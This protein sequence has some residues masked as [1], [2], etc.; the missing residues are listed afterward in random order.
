MT[1]SIQQIAERIR[2]LTERVEKAGATY[3]P[4]EGVRSAA[5]R[6]LAL[7]EKW[8]RGGLS[9]GEASDQGIGS[10]VQRAVNLKNGDAISL[11]TVKRMAAFFSRHAKNYAPEKKESDGGPTAGTIAWLL[12]GGNAGRDWASGIVSRIEK[13][14]PS[15]SAVHSPTTDWRKE[16]RLD[17]AVE[18]TLEASAA[19]HNSR[20]KPARKVA[21][22]TLRRVYR[23]AQKDYSATVVKSAS[24]GA[25]ALARVSSF[26]RL[27]R[28]GHPDDPGY[29][30]DNDL[31]PEGHP[32][33]ISKARVDEVSGR[34][35][36]LMERI[37]KARERWPAG[38]ANGMGG[39]FKPK[40]GG[41]GGTGAA[42]RAS[43]RSKKPLAQT[44]GGG[45]KP[46]LPDPTPFLYAPDKL[47]T[48][49]TR[50]NNESHNKKIGTI[51]SYG[52]AGNVNGILGMKFA[53][54]AYGI[55]ATKFAN[56]VLTALGSEHR[57]APGQ[58][59]G[60]HP[61]LKTGTDTPKP[62]SPPPEPPKPP[63]PAPAPEKPKVA[64]PA[65]K[66]AK[67]IDEAK[68]Q[69]ESFGMT[70][71]TVPKT[72][73]SSFGYQKKTKQWMT[74][75]RFLSILNAIGPEAA[76]LSVEHPALLTATHL[77]QRN[78]TGRALGQYFIGSHRVRLRT[79]GH[80]AKDGK[81]ESLS[82]LHKWANSSSGNDGKV[83]WTVDQGT[84]VAQYLNATL[85]HEAG[86]AIDYKYQRAL[87]KAVV[88]AANKANIS[89]KKYMKG[90]ISTYGGKNVSETVA[91]LTALYTSAD[92]K[93]G[94][95]TAPLEAALDKFFEF[96]NGRAR[97]RIAMKVTK[98]MEDD[99]VDVR[100][101]ALNEIDEIEESSVTPPPPPPGYELIPD[102]GDAV[103]YKTPD[104]SEITLE[105]L[106]ESGYYGEDEGDDE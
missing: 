47:G 31:L 34:V 7:R 102:T 56:L 86:H 59:T 97:A 95:I 104:G 99:M 105:D 23:R 45:A 43:D 12:W 72:Y 62:P 80:Y 3:T 88:D 20:V 67:T 106:I 48:G 66:Q 17:D 22:E 71:V 89:L 50:A 32:R 65:Y 10:G 26:L 41:A 76:R 77:E 18:A 27:A 101:A 15:P 2:A 78:P 63:T 94:T 4:P 85:R 37:D 81:N 1:A 68:A 19:A 16:D 51:Q 96:A 14:S 21:P 93:R 98:F 42:P 33:G 83:P 35:A 92:Y 91:E 38:S 70:V 74:E 58:K 5:A 73:Q 52:Q 9:N 55:K 82:G 44:A 54:N 24:E 25:Y 40:E 36:A 11:E 46:D 100:K 64:A 69:L 84:T 53:T 90:N 57:V 13:M 29:I 61:G 49:A 6:G 79:P 28:R 8:K 30:Q 87:A 39:K 103:R 60:E 75:D